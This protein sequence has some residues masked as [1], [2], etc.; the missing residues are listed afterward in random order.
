MYTLDPSLHIHETNTEVFLV[1]SYTNLKLELN[2]HQVHELYKILEK[3]SNQHIDIES[4]LQKGE[5]S[6]E[7]QIIK[8]LL[9]KNLLF[10]NLDS[11]KNLSEHIQIYC[12][13]LWKEAVEASIPDFKNKISLSDSINFDVLLEENFLNPN[14]FYVFLTEDSIFIS[15]NFLFKN[16]QQTFSDNYY[17][18]AFYV[19]IDK[20]P[21]I[22][23]LGESI[24]KIN[25]RNYLNETKNLV[26]NDLSNVNLSQSWIMDYH[27]N[28]VSWNMDY[29]MFYP[30]TVLVFKNRDLDKDKLIFGLSDDECIINLILEMREYSSEN[31]KWDEIKI[32]NNVSILGMQERE[33]DFSKKLF[34]LYFERD[35]KVSENE[36]EYI[37]IIDNTSICIPK[38]YS[39]NPDMLLFTYYYNHIIS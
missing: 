35:Y 3:L 2:E 32:L 11:E 38:Y 8:L 29:Q 26:I 10:K 27:L 25:M 13:S 19:L 37:Y 31:K 1:S 5:K 15:P 9:N 18:Y 4:C 23:I 16:E 6:F 36:E 17:I 34:N 7:L 30:L 22:T 39:S 21:E 12:N 28:G 14:K 20:I 33:R 24:L